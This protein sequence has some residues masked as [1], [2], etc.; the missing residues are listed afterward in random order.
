MLSIDLIA[1]I[2]IEHDPEGLIKMG[3]PEDEYSSEAEKI[4]NRITTENK[5]SIIDYTSTIVF[6]FY[7]AFGSYSDEE[8]NFGYSWNYLNK[9]RVDKYKAIGKLI[10]ELS[11]EK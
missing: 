4:Y 6:V 9:F 8:G 2:L 3:A 10:F 1:G 5:Q 11:N 7:E